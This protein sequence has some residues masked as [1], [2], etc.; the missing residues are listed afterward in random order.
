[1]IDHW[2]ALATTA[3]LVFV[4]VMGVFAIA[5]FWSGEGAPTVV[6]VGIAMAVTM[7]I[8]P[9]VNANHLLP[10]EF[11]TTWAFG[12][13]IMEQAA[14]GMIIGFVVSMVFMIFDSSA[15][16]YD[17]QMGLGIINV[18]DPFHATEASVMG[19]VQSFVAMLIFIAMDGPHYVLYALQKSFVLVPQLNLNSGL[20]T[21]VIF[22]TMSRT[23]YVSLVFVLPMIGV[24]FISHLVL[25]ILSKASPQLNVMVVGFPINITIG[26]ITFWYLLGYFNDFIPNIF[27]GMFA[28]LDQLI[29]HVL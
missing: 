27:A 1:M 13:E 19:Q 25:G 23:F 24:L 17:S 7:A 20:L 28:E 2:I 18:F 16:F 11:P 29:T 14:I 22:N 9:M 12:F 3:L 5:P 6:K 4:R 21:K 15:R 26:F 10:V 8:F